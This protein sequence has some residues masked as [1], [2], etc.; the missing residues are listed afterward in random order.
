M[1]AKTV[2]KASIKTQKTKDKLLGEI[3]IHK[4]LKH[5]N[6][7][8][9][10]DCFEDDVNVYILLE[11]CSNN[12]LMNMLRK[13]KTFTEI[14]SKFFL[15]QIIGGV[16]YMH[17][18]GV[19]HR[20]LKL[21]NIFLDDQ[22]NIKIGD[23]G[24]A[25]VLSSENERKKTICGTPNYIAPEVLYGKKEG[26]SYEVDVWS[27][28]VILYAMVVGKPPF[29]SKDVDTIYKRI[30]DNDYHYPDTNLSFEVKNL[31][32]C[33]LRL[34]PSKRIKLDE[35]LSHPFFKRDFPDHLSDLSLTE[36]P[37]FPPIT[38]AQSETNFIN[39]KVASR[40]M[41]RPVSH[42]RKSDVILKE[43]A[44]NNVDPVSEQKVLPASLSPAS[45]KEK[46]K[47][48]M[49]QKDEAHMARPVLSAHKYSR[50]SETNVISD[51]PQPERASLGKP[52]R[53]ISSSENHTNNENVAKTAI[54]NNARRTSGQLKAERE[55]MLRTRPSQAAFLD[56]HVNPSK[57]ACVGWASKLVNEFMDK[58]DN[59]VQTGFSRDPY[60]DSNYKPHAVFITK[61]VDYSNKYGIAYQ[62]STGMVGVLFKDKS[63]TQM[64]T[65]VESFDTIR[66]STS[67]NRWIIHHTTD[68]SQCLPSHT[69]KFR[70]VK[71]M[72]SYM[73][74]NLRES[75]SSDEGSCISHEPISPSQSSVTFLV[76]Y[77]RLGQIV[78]FQ[79]NNGSFQFN[80]PDHT[81]ILMS[82]D[83]NTIGFIDSERRLHCWS[84]S[85][86]CICCQPFYNQIDSD[87][88]ADL[89]DKL[90][91]ISSQLVA[92]QHS[93]S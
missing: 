15:T 74:K 51:Y 11:M 46:Y 66:Y 23:F 45:T 42:P 65:V 21:G 40:L 80:F 91:R 70:L 34:D 48:V 60:P 47:M 54:Q 7:V 53:I 49:L 38:A 71:T 77:M 36:K 63:T 24:L 75:S 62:L 86:G 2:A 4:V 89:Y 31:I 82:E 59:S 35:S 55:A 87:F 12:N 72:Y 44:T 8:K 93:R 6:I 73:Q 17:E 27:V 14:E 85:F 84:L 16:A 92:I 25:A 20:D 26:H 22:M 88:L 50:M 67:N 9:F 3:R 18:Y 29:Q 1:A 76:H 13:R 52:R 37:I 5:P 78:M 32:N 69:N 41:L 81:K 56:C 30:K 28:G 90:E 61:W 10:I 58:L 79:L 33:F 43:I 68:I 39:C 19:I 83:A 57:T 64:N